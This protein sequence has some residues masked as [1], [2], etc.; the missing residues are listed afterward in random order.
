MTDKKRASIWGARTTPAEAAEA[1]KTHAAEEIAMLKAR[2]TELENLITGMDR[3][4]IRNQDQLRTEYEARLDKA[5]GEN[6]A[7]EWKLV[8]ATDD[9]NAARAEVTALR[10]RLDTA[11]IDLARLTDQ[12][13]ALTAERDQTRT[14]AR[15]MAERLDQWRHLG[16]GACPLCADGRWYE[17]EHQHD[18]PVSMVRAWDK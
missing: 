10:N 15:E 8:C 11:Q 4:A 17:G 12:N 6:A 16:G 9:L 5:D 18:C 1:A 14:V 3:I 13:A 2:V 7:L